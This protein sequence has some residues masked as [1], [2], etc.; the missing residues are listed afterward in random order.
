M[1]AEK[2]ILPMR[3]L[4]ELE[5]VQVSGLWLLVLLLSSFLFK[6]QSFIEIIPNFIL[7]YQ[8]LSK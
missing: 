6:E 5:S 1:V 8:F 2:N 4:F 7:V 3:A